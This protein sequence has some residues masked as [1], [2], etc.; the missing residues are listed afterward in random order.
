[1]NYTTGS[2]VTARGRDWVVQP[3]I[4]DGWLLLRPLGGLDEEMVE[5]SP[6]LEEIRPATFAL[7]DPERPGD[8]RSCALLRDAVRLGLRATT[9]P[10]RSFG[11]IAVEPRPYQ[12]VPLLMAM[13]QPVV[14]LLVA[15]DVGIGKTVE[16]LLVAREL[17]DRGE[18]RR[19]SVLCPP[20]LAEQWQKEMEEKF[21][22]EAELVLPSTVSRLE[23]GLG[24]GT[25]LFEKY[26]FTVVSLDYIKAR[27]HRDDFRR[28]CPEFV[29]VDEA[30]TCASESGDRKSQQR[31]ALVADLS[32]K[33]D[34]HMI[35]VT[36]TP[37]NGKEEVF[38][39]L[40][41]L[42]DPSLGDLPADLAGSSNEKARRK[43]AAYFIQ[44]RRGDIRA[45]MDADTPFPERK[46][47]EGT[48]NASPGWKE[49][50]RRALSLAQD[51]ITSAKGSTRWRQRISWWSALALLRAISSSPAAAAQTLRSRAS[52][53]DME[54][55]G[56]A[57]DVEQL[58]A[59]ASRCVFDLDSSEETALTDTLPG[60]DAS[61][62]EE[63]SGSRGSTRPGRDRYTALARLAESLFGSK[64]P[65]LQGIIPHLQ[66]LLADGYSPVVFCRF[67][68][69]AQYVAANLRKALPGCE[70][71]AVTGML[72]PAERE[73]RVAAL[74]GK[75]K[76]LLVCTDCLSEGINLQEHFNAV[77]HYDLS[78][79]PTRHEQREG[80]VDRFG[81]PAR[82]VRM[83]TW[84]GKDNPMDGMILEVLLK[85][86]EEI[87]R[88]L[89]ISV[90]VPEN[91]ETVVET[92][93]NGLLLRKKPPMPMRNPRQLT[94]PGIEPYLAPGQTSLKHLSEQWDDMARVVEKRSQTLFAQRSVKVDDVAAML[95]AT[96]AAGG[97]AVTVERFVTTAWTRLGGVGKTSDRGGHRS[98]A[99]HFD[100]NCRKLHR[101][102]ELPADGQGF[103]FN[104]PAGDGE[105]VLTRTHPL[106][107]Q[108]AAYIA[109]TAFDTEGEPLV[110]RCGVMRTKAV[111]RLTSLLLCRLRFQIT[112]TGTGKAEGGG[113]GTA[114]A[115]REN[116][117]LAEEC[118]CLAFEGRPDRAG[119]LTQERVTSLLEA[120]PDKNVGRE[121][122]TRWVA[123]VE[124]KA[125]RL[126]EHLAQYGRQR[127][128]TLLEEHRKAR[129]AADAKGLR[130][131]VDPQGTPDLLGLFVFLP[132]ID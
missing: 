82:E 101:G 26:P 6:E 103:V 111:D 83:L 61:S 108:L 91:V 115:R 27:N 129:S 20:Q 97:N 94:L 60:A 7:P 116:V 71:D 45:Y 58:D 125:D 76:R 123:R 29:I 95:S 119:W 113:T 28:A 53:M 106:V 64:D 34:R 117:A 130:Y 48:W 50:F 121:E 21:H 85:K 122:A 89:G 11:H 35:F 105:T 51:N 118:A 39:A 54:E 57:E 62:D 114:D 69:T 44:R 46:S 18:I 37:H 90:P 17:L 99:F 86:H 8:A 66:A 132:C 79:N 12:L 1:M 77:V 9:G 72:P 68:T 65:K 74:A 126:G 96:W 42:L 100:E 49:L 3:P 98:L 127:A 80:R 56:N 43:L 14:R 24:S 87:R 41:R 40:L 67:I 32:R 55:T 70:V 110:A 109:Q 10:F 75:E 52:G 128:R 16:A 84:W 73:E 31:H 47:R 2:L 78:W 22:I 33:G 112:T 13:K 107:E 102:L 15:D 104:P 4:E 30:H 23:R 124:E 25:S 19:M 36:A 5:L 38:R 131:R 93:V 88:S 63:S 81:Q 59:M 92:L 120:R